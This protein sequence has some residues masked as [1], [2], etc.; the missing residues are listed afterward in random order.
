MGELVMK[1]ARVLCVLVVL[2][3]SAI[4]AHAQ[5]PIDS[6]SVIPDPTINFHRPDPACDPGIC[7]DFAYT[8]TNSA[9]GGE[10]FFGTVTPLPIPPEYSCTYNGDPNACF[11][12]L[13][14][15]DGVPPFPIDFL[16][17]GFFVPTPL[18]NG[19]GCGP[20]T[21]FSIDAAGIGNPFVL[22]VPTGQLSCLDPACPGG[23]ISLDPI[24]TTPELGTALLYLTGLVSLVGFARRRFGA[25]FLT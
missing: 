7:V 10:I 14:Y 12:D 1:I 3:S 18:C 13:E 9:T 19:V 5:T 21:T 4:A 11:V 23:T 22:T 25:N 24:P 2:A 15:S 8:G 16:G 6:N 20:Q 17:V